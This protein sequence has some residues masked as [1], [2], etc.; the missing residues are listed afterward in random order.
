M[1]SSKL[2]RAY[3]L[4]ETPAPVALAAI[5]LEFL[6]QEVVNLSKLGFNNP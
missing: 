5:G 3:D 1:F 6:S 4:G 2:D